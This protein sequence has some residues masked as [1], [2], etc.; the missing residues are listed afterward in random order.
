MSFVSINW[1]PGPRDIRSFG[2]VLA[3][4]VTLIVVV[5]WIGRATGL[6][7]RGG[8]SRLSTTSVVLVAT[9]WGIALLA[10]LA[11]RLARP[12][13]YA[14]MGLAF[15]L[16]TISSTLLLTAVYFALF[17]PMSLLFRVAKRDAL[18]RRWPPDRHGSF[19]HVIGG[20]PQKDQ[21]QKQF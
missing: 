4:G 10:Q 9:A 15:V 20:K 13:Y 6:V 7:G 11:P 18:Q 1:S 19:W 12:F 17:T 16:G 5:G 2:R 8:V 3:I 14:W 21:Y